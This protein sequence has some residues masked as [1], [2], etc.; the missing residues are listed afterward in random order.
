MFSIFALLAACITLQ[1][2]PAKLIDRVVVVR[3]E[4]SAISIGVANDY[5]AKRHVKNV[6]SVFCADS[7]TS[8][9]N[10]TTTWAIYQSAIEAPLKAFLAKHPEVDFIVLTKG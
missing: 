4:K 9:A 5:C 10:E 2:K 8:A 3:N 6:V 1:L 7:T